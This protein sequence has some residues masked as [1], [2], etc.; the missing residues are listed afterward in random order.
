MSFGRPSLVAQTTILVHK[1][2]AFKEIS[3]KYKKTNKAS[4]FIQLFSGINFG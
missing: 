2:I 4:E 3:K 1:N